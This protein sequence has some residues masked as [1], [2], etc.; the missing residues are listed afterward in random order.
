MAPSNKFRKLVEEEKQNLTNLCNEWENYLK[1]SIEDDDDEDDSNTNNK[2]EDDNDGPPSSRT[3]SSNKNEKKSSSSTTI[4]ENKIPD[5]EDELCGLVRATTG[6]GRM[7]IQQRFEQFEQLI[8]DAE[9]KTS[10]KPIGEDDLQGFWDMIDFQIVDMKQKFHVLE[11][12]KANNWKLPAAAAA[13]ETSIQPSTISSTSK[14]KPKKTVTK[15]SSS[16]SSTSKQQS[17][18][19]SAPK[20]NIRDF[21]AQKRREAQEAQKA[22]KDDEVDDEKT[23]PE[24]KLCVN[25]I[26]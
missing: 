8:R 7:L 6:Q 3:R 13:E 2:N 20:S 18:A 4:L 12:A 15:P 21:I 16:S 11:T 24:C 1:I 25:P 26:T 9:E 19:K 17:K 22:K 10:E 23:S 5:D 14:P